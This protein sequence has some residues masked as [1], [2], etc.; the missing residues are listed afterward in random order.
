MRIGQPVTLTRRRLRQRG[1]VPRHGRGPR[2]RHRRG[3]RAA[4]GAERDRQLDQGRAAR[5]GA[6]RARPEGARRAIRCASACRWTPRSTSPTQDGKTLADAPRAGAADADAVS[7]A[8]RDRAPRRWCS[9]SI[10]ANLG[11]AQ[12]PAATPAAAPPRIAA[13]GGQRHVA[14]TPR[15]ARPRADR[16]VAS[17][18]H[19]MSAPPAAAPHRA[20]APLEGIAR[21]W[22]T[23]AL[24]AATFMIVLDTSIANVSIPAISGDL[25][26]SATPG[27]L[28]HH[29]RSPW[30]TP[31]RCR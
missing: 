21:V 1:R 8:R 26:V 11:A 17:P 9:R 14:G 7:T 13:R 22:G 27:H 2:R 5:A 19:A 3:V 24:S 31:S 28:G 10:A 6:H 30:P 4:A 16:H 29:R 23:I 18:R 25:G 12:R 15:T 20:A